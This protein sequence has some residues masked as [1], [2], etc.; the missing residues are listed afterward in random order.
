MRADEIMTESVI[1][2]RAT[3]TIADAIAV[4]AEKDVRHL[5]VLGD[6]G[7]LVGMLSD[8]DIRSL[9][10]TRALDVQ[11]SQRAQERLRQSIASA[12]SANVASIGPEL[13]MPEVIDAMLESGVG[14]LPVVD[15]DT[16]QLL[17]IVS[18]VDV[19]RAL[20]DVSAQA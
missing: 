6:A 18:Y 3:Q 1:T 15:E 12:M 7:Q 11:T 16:D 9:G 17:G 8:R 5:P 2:I 10:L 20:R 14:A 13:E 4:L 19:L